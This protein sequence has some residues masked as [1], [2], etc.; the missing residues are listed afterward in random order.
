M[1]TREYLFRTTANLADQASLPSD[2]LRY[3]DNATY[4]TGG[5][6]YPVEYIPVEKIPQM[7]NNAILAAY[8]DSP[9]IAIFNRKINTFP[10]SITLAV[11]YYQRPADLWRSDNSILL[12][13]TDFMPQETEYAI[14]RG[15]FERTVRMT[16]GLDVARQLIEK[17]EMEGQQAA[18]EWYEVEFG[19]QIKD[20]QPFV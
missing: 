6:D 20:V 4:T 12:T 17:N 8:A 5:V 7:N 18:L 10:G 1:P 19:R 14:V 3:A 13:A 9:K 2:W 16:S 11:S 15:T